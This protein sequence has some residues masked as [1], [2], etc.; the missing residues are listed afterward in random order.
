MGLPSVC[1]RANE[2]ARRD[3]ER[4]RETEGAGGGGE[5]KKGAARRSGRGSTK[6]KRGDEI[7]AAYKRAGRGRGCGTSDGKPYR[8]FLA[9]RAE[10]SVAFGSTRSH[11][12]ARGAAAYIGPRA[13][14]PEERARCKEVAIRRRAS[15]RR[16]AP[17]VAPSTARPLSRHVLLL[18][19]CCT[20]RR[21]L[22]A[23]TT[24]R[25]G[26][27]SARP[28]APMFSGRFD[29]SIWAIRLG[30]ALDELDV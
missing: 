15:R 17:A 3:K 18:V 14:A 12:L 24:T 28:V 6:R 8:R 19:A 23:V 9:E 20:L 11:P 22:T 30:R 7:A 4:A 29:E 16:R 13:G 1:T 2:K 10:A 21:S 5:R 25:V 27:C 26:V